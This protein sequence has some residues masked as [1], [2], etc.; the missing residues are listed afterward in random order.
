MPEPAVHI[1]GMREFQAALARADR[2]SRLGVRRELRDVARPIANDSQQLAL[3]TIA[4]M[5]SSP[6]WARMRIGVTRTLVYVAPRQRGGKGGPGRRPN[7]ADLMMSRAMEPALERHRG[8]L[9][10]NVE[11]MLDRVAGQFNH[12]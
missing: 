12:G 3:S 9:E 10:A 11:L 4:G 1:S 2:S 8:E 6:A 7:L 5:S